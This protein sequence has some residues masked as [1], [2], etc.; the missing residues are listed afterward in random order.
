MD[1]ITAL[2][3]DPDT[4]QL[5]SLVGGG[6]KTTTIFR[7]ARDL[8]QRGKRVLVTTTTNMF[9]PAE[10]ECDALVLTPLQEDA[11]LGTRPGGT[12]ICLAAGLI[13]EKLKLKSVAPAFIDHLFT[14]GRFDVILVEAD[15]A[16]RKP[17]KAP[18]DYEP[19]LPTATTLVMGCIGLDAVGLPI[20]ERHVHREHLFARVT[21]TRPG[22]RIDVATI[23]RLIVSP[24]GLFRAAPPGA[25]RLVLL[26]KADDEERCRAGEAVAA[27]LQAAD[28][29]RC[30]VA[31][32]SAAEGRVYSRHP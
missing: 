20:E 29:P 15:G 2:G 4:P 32:A 23:A 16:K 28:R 18:A 24:D 25:A 14:A 7:L 12:I 6:G 30:S 17:I 10:D 1:C 9:L 5:I 19:V 8:K 13:P 21:G 31:V 22:D 11:L 3:I 26:N 27:L